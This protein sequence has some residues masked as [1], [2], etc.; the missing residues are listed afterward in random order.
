MQS[1]VFYAF[2]AAILWGFTY[3]LD[4]KSL[5]YL[6]PLQFKFLMALGATIILGTALLLR[7]EMSGIAP[8]INNPQK[9]IWLLASLLTTCS[10]TL[11]IAA[12]I[13]MENPTSAAIIEVSY[14]LFT[15]LFSW[16]LFRDVH[17]TKDLA[18]GGALIIAGVVYIAT[19]TR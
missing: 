15:A 13:K 6:S 19:T 18:I 10:A 3:T 9:Y 1:W 7:G 2:M 11:L 14:P 17:I 12:T 5:T 4:G 8:V 16:L